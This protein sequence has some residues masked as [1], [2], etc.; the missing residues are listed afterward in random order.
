MKKRILSFLFA[1]F[2][3]IPCFLLTACG[4][5]P[6]ADQNDTPSQD[7]GSSDN[8]GN[9]NKDDDVS[10]I[11]TLY[12]MRVVTYKYGGNTAQVIWF[13][14]GKTMV[15]D[16]RVV[17]C[18]SDFSRFYEA[19]TNSTKWD[20]ET[21]TMIIDY[22]V[23]TNE[24]KINIDA[25][26]FFN[27]FSI[28]TYYRPDMGIDLEYWYDYVMGDLYYDGIS[29]EDIFAISPEHLQG[30]MKPYLEGNLNLNIG[31]ENFYYEYNGDYLLSLYYA[32][33]FG[34]DIV[35]IQNDTTIT[36]TFK[37]S[38]RTYSYSVDFYSPEPIIEPT[39][40]VQ[41]EYEGGPIKYISTIDYD[42]TAEYN[43]LV[44]IHYG[45]FGVLYLDWATKNVLTSV[46]DNYNPTK[47]FDVMLG[48]YKKESTAENL[49]LAY[50]K[51][52]TDYRNID[53]YPITKFFDKTNIETNRLLLALI[54]GFGDWNKSD[55][56]SSW[57]TRCLY[58][59]YPETE[60]VLLTANTYFP[61]ISASSMKFPIVIA[62]KDYTN[63]IREVTDEY[64]IDNNMLPTIEGVAVESAWN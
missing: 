12:D 30:R 23:V 37:H 15:I 27:Y 14:D 4:Q 48:S 61:S 19:F 21:G 6:P 60:R 50:Q 44:S 9:D 42:Q 62:K 22:L 5:K 46:L 47:K 20:N 54:Y 33:F 10:T 31:D 38:G 40:R 64:L 28:G 39:G 2:L 13:P 59:F 26:L 51:I 1:I 18:D 24:S 16:P 52:F 3:I 34:Y 53:E 57:E 11:T 36:Q 8:G 7:T 17:G 29:M 49:H 45:D 43:T 56:V 55:K 25:Q 41:Y 35:K 58:N 63:I 32:E